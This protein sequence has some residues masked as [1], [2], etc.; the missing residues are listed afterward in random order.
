MNRYRYTAD[1]R[2]Q[3]RAAPHTTN[4]RIFIT[5]S[6]KTTKRRLPTYREEHST[7]TLLTLTRTHPW[8]ICLFT[9]KS[10]RRRRQCQHRP[11]APCSGCRARPARSCGPRAP[12][13]PP[14][15]GAPPRRSP[16]CAGTPA[17]PCW[18][19]T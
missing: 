19:G 15:C 18:R 1:P 12:R 13:P 14:S 8:M 5:H 11:P 17:A 4:T 2:P 10:C 16:G 6:G 7:T 3:P 9:R